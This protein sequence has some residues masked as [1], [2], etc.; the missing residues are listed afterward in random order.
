MCN[1]SGL[2]NDSLMTVFLWK[3]PSLLR[4]GP[5][6]VW[7]AIWGRPAA[8]G[9]L[10]YPL[11]LNPPFPSS[12]RKAK[13][14]RIWP[15]KR[16]RPAARNGKKMVD[17]WRKKQKNDLKSHFLPF[18]GHVFPISARWPFCIFWQI[19]S[20]FR[21]S[22]RFPSS[23]LTRNSP[24]LVL[25]DLIENDKFWLVLRLRVARVRSGHSLGGRTVPAVPVSSVK[26][27]I[28]QA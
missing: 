6:R 5:I 21:F 15:K 25:Y 8:Q 4:W 9:L 20:H 14:G 19:F 17:K 7:W 10:L 1:A 16:K 27:K 12:R 2:M 26:C 11:K 13:M 18:F 24:V 23:G 22:A 28:L 3:S